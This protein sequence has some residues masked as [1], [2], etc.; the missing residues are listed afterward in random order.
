[1]KHSFMV[2]HEDKVYK[3][4]PTEKF[5]IEPQGEFCDLSYHS[6][7]CMSEKINFFLMLSVANVTLKKIGLGHKYY[8]LTNI[9][10]FFIKTIKFIFLSHCEIRDLHIIVHKH[11]CPL[12]YG[13]ST[14]HQTQ[15]PEKFSLIIQNKLFYKMKDN[16]TIGYQSSFLLYSTL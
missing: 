7:L 9:H 4:L 15:K 14:W 12:G 8:S 13:K 1:M 16:V 10:N 3:E 5:F 6:P 2:Y 11:Q